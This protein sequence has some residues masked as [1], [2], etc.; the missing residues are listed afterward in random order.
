MVLTVV[1]GAMGVAV[2]GAWP[3]GTPA[4]LEQTLAMPPAVLPDP[5]PPS[6]DKDVRDAY[7]VSNSLESDNFVARW[8]NSGGITEGNAQTMLNAFEVAWIAQ[9]DDMDH[10]VPHG[11]DRY[12][13]NVYVGNTGEG[14][15]I[16]GAAGYATYDSAGYPMVVMSPEYAAAGDYAALVAAHEF[17]HLVQF[18]T[19]AY[20]YSG[21]AAWYWEATAS[22]IEVE[23]Y[24][25]EP[26]YAVFLAGFAFLPHL[27]LN[28]FD[29]PDSGVL[30]ELHQYG[31]FIF[32]RY[33][34]E[35]VGDWRLI[36]DSWVEPTSSDPLESLEDGVAE[37]GYDLDHEIALFAA[38][39]ATWDYEHGDWYED[40]LIVYESW[41]GS[42]DHRVA[43]SVSR[44]G[45]DDWDQ[46]SEDLLP[47]RY[48]YNILEMSRPYDGTLALGFEGDSSG[49]EGMDA[50]W[51]VVVVVSG[52]GTRE[53]T[54][55]EGASIEHEI[56]DVSDVTSV[57][58]A[59]VPSARR[60]QEGETFDYT[61]RLY[62]T[63]GGDSE[64]GS[65][66]PSL[67]SFYD[68]D[69][70]GCGCVHVPEPRGLSWLLALGT[71]VLCRRSR[72][73]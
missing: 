73:T 27:A 35:H 24:P 56:G 23:V 62:F 66:A 53:Y 45:M 59:V 28:F 65:N 3:C 20:S 30:Q 1:I 67:S 69:D 16:S 25:D 41:Y 29:Y 7:S 72:P 42:E 44:G 18:G 47:E 21:D 12:K 10:P 63:E 58:V 26:D 70:E 50:D 48:G 31:A 49:S 4:I 51:R 13:V 2:A 60:R 6:P 64:S 33:L 61:F 17:Y 57:H 36:R 46:V 54:V 55:L 37:L 38:H 40:A 11:A 32:P 71:L 8:G 34:A 43:K 5:G 14:P 22:W 19:E 68:L 52:G 9:I 39:N 15:S